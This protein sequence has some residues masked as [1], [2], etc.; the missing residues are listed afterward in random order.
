M[1]V[2]IIFFVSISTIICGVYRPDIDVNE[3]KKLANQE[4]FDCVG[5]VLLINNEPQGSCV[6]ISENIVITNAHVVKEVIT[7]LDTDE[8]KNGKIIYNQPIGE[9]YRTSDEMKVKIGDNYYEIES[10]KIHPDYLD[11]NSQRIDLAVLITKK[12]IEGIDFPNINLEVLKLGTQL[13]GVGYGASGPGSNASLVSA[14]GEKIY[15]TNILDSINS[16]LGGGIFLYTD[17]DSDDGSSNELG[18]NIQTKYEFCSTGGD[19][20][21]PYFIEKD[22]KFILVGLVMGSKYNIDNLQKGNYYGTVN[23]IVEIRSLINW[24]Y[25]K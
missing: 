18:Q 3:L 22:G 4:Q 9:R 2:L 20:G 12:K 14:K 10:L 19:S 13:I 5:E 7:K 23:T 15:G 1:R 24:I 8:T 25:G 11:R 21:C 6:A 17:F 16:N